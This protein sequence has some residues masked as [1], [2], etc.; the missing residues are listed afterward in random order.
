MSIFEKL[1]L[2]FSLLIFSIIFDKNAIMSWKWFMFYRGKSENAPLDN[3]LLISDCLWI[4][5]K[6]K[7]EGTKLNGTLFN[8]VWVFFQ[9]PK[10]AVERESEAEFLLGKEGW[11]NQNF[12]RIKIQK[13]F[14]DKD[15]SSL[16]NKVIS[17]HNG[18]WMSA[19]FLVMFQ[20]YGLLLNVKWRWYY[21]FTLNFLGIL[22]EEM[23][24]K[25]ILVNCPELWC[26][27]N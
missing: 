12:S 13:S 23:K 21:L 3:V 4:K 22:T 7:M 17:E 5:K 11:Q 10:G 15:S 9:K 24:L 18:V 16:G 27:T 25:Y 6:K 8:Q 2:N 20:G 26:H 14:K 1:I 19:L